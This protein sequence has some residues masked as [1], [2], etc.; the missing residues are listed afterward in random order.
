MSVSV[1][2]QAELAP[3]TTLKVGGRADRLIVA[4]SQSQLID[5]VEDCDANSRALLV[6][7]GGS[8]VVLRDDDFDGDVVLV[9]TQ[10]IDVVDRSDCAGVTLTVAAGEP[11]D[12][13]VAQAVANGWVGIESLS[14][15]PGSTGATPIQNVGAYGQEVAQTIAQVRTFDRE[16]KAIKT[17]AVADC[18]FGYRTSK[19]RRNPRW[20][21]LDVTFQ[22]ELG[23]DSAPIAYGE[24]AQA[25]GVAVGQRA[26][27]AQ[28][29][30][31]VLKLRR[32]K[33]MV[34]DDRDPESQSVGSFFTNPVLSQ[35]QAS[36]LPADAPRWPQPDGA[37][38]TSAAWLIEQAGFSKGYSN[39]SARISAH[40][41]LALVTTQGAKASDVLALADSITTAVRG[42]FGIELLVEPTVMG[43]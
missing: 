29:R 20:V 12:E 27:L 22:L 26:P 32:S 37:V 7:A 5:A 2:R 35:E 15:I 14:G 43:S 41:T 1:Q 33:S 19:F 25:L 39:G 3:L 13:V 9:R 23:T 10:G 11:W 18:D 17:F 28:V 21:I 16:E 42:T 40:H 34:L 31:T 8:N 36:A 24:L 4:E 30:E 38:K 6:L